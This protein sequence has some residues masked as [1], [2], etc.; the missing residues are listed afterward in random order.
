MQATFLTSQLNQTTA[1][2][3]EHAYTF[4]PDETAMGELAGCTLSSYMS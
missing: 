1:S 4:S 3:R 2:H